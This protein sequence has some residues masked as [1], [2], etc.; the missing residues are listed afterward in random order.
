MPDSFDCGSATMG[1]ALIPR[2]STKVDAQTTGACREC[3]NA[4]RQWVR[5][6]SYGDVLKLE[7]KL[8]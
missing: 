1:A 2:S 4:P 5:S 3:V 8:S 6:C 7:L